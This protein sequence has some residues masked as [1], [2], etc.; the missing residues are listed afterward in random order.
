VDVEILVSGDDERA[1]RSSLWQWM[2]GDE[3]LSHVRSISGPIGDEELGSAT[4]LL[5]V[6]VGS[7]GV[8]MA[9]VRAL[10]AWIETRRSN[11]KVTVVAGDQRVEL[12]ATNVDDVGPLL[13]QVLRQDEDS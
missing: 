13:R 8:A 7:G 2:R 12:E 9:L 3:Q 11:V 1:E 10:T 4:E 6:A 5:T